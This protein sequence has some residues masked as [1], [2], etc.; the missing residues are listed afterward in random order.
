M[1]SAAA[2]VG[3]SVRRRPSYRRV[4][5]PFTGSAAS[6]RALEIAC[7]LAPEHG[8]VL[9]AVFVI[10]VSSLLPLDARMDVEEITARK[11]L[12]SAEATADAFGIHAN[13]RRLR[14]RDA[15][16]AIV[17]LAGQT[18][19]ELVVL[20]APRKRR[21]NGRRLGFGPTVRH[22]LAKAPCPVLLVASPPA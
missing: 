2:T 18:R 13:L 9:V 6:E 1:A 10:E 17:E 8:A 14:A 4:L 5:V 21:A 22:V 15:G 7:S 12:R 11:A 16:R 20:A 19:A 3:E